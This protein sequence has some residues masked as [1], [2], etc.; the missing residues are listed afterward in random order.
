MNVNRAPIGLALVLLLF[1]SVVCSWGQGLEDEKF[2]V[3]ARL[4][5][6]DEP[7]KKLKDYY[8]DSLEKL[9]GE[10]QAEGD[11]DAV[12]QIKVEQDW[13]AGEPV[14]RPADVFPELVRRREIYD[15]KMVELRDERQKAKKALLESYSDSLA[16][17]Q[18]D[19]T[20]KGEIEMAVSC[21]AE[22]ARVE[23]LLKKLEPK[24][25]EAPVGGVTPASWKAPQGGSFSVTPE[26]MSLVGP[27]LLKGAAI[28][29][30]NQELAEGATL[31]GECKPNGKWTGFILAN[32]QAGTPYL[33][34]FS[35]PGHDGVWIE[36][37]IRGERR[38]LGAEDGRWK[39]GEWIDFELKRKSGRFHV[40]LGR[41]RF[42]IPIPE[43]I[44]GGYVG[45]VAFQ[46]SSIVVRNLKVE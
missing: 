30:S 10:L 2:K 9:T 40:S 32:S 27:G 4:E 7:I 24:V 38:A 46:E 29:I 20:K 6:L 45:I 5:G 16:K 18:K 44:T 31:S 26:E 39:A 33:C 22:I 25:V 17:L 3:D 42:R 1:C 35:K 37:H 14:E 12:L 23:S 15:K 19:Y 28:A 21:K 13:L 43:E 8:R 11:L 41:E 36:L 34:V